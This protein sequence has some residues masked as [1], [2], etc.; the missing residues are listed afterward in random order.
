MLSQTRRILDFIYPAHCQLCEHSLTHGQHLCQSCSDSLNYTAAPFCQLCGECYDGEITT[1]F[2]CPNCNNLNL[3]FEFARAPLHA[4][5][6][7]ISLLHDFKYSRQIHLSHE[8]AKLLE[9]GL[10]DDPRFRPYLDGGI[11]VPVPL[12]WSRLRKRKFNQAE[13]MARCLGKRTGLRCMNVLKRRRNTASQ[14]RFSRSMR[15]ENLRD[16]FELRPRQRNQVKGRRVILVD[17]I[18]TTGSTA[19]ECTKMMLKHGAHSVAVLT[20]LRG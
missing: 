14:T 2:V 16:A 10:G 13:E 6:L 5:G 19:N 8:L 7:G 3:D 1:D 17:D 12:H 11:L 20:L 9:T 18:F 15:L 4:D